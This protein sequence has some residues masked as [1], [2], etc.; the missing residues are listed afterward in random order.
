MASSTRA[1]GDEWKHVSMDDY[2]E[3]FGSLEIDSSI[4][5]GDDD[6]WF[7]GRGARDKSKI[8]KAR[9][10]LAA[11]TTASSKS[12]VSTR[13]QQQL[14]A[15]DDSDSAPLPD[16]KWTSPLP[17]I[18]HQEFLHDSYR[19]YTNDF[20]AVDT[21]FFCII[22][23][24]LPF[25]FAIFAAHDF[26]YHISLSQIPASTIRAPC[27]SLPTRKTKSTICA[28]PCKSRGGRRAT[29]RIT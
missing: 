25:L 7:K 16:G 9:S 19:F 23:I 17:M 14:R 5:S 28:R 1:F 3:S 18:K 11:K 20:V 26:S 29:R 21:L 15:K 12:G 22:S 10:A 6:G 8:A 13:S 4:V 24:N 27:T 2:E